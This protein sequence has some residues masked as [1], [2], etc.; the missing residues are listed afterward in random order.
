LTAVFLLTEGH[1]YYL[2]GLYPLCWAAGAV[3]LP[4][5]RLRWLP[6]WPAYLVS[7][8]VAVVVALPVRPV[9]MLGPLD[10]PARGSLGW[11]ELADTVA[12]TYRSLPPQA[13]AGAVVVAAQDWQAAALDQFGPDRGLPRPYSPH[14]GYWYFGAPPDTSGV[15]IF[16]GADEGYL[17]RY[18]GE[19]RRVSTVDNPKGIPILNAD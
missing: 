18:F 19:V 1:S 7:A 4:R 5:C 14:R 2:A 8:A 13:R 10:L 12:A 9:W 17:H 3:E 16:V 6:T 15:V 11:P